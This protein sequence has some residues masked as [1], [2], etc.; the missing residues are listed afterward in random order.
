VRSGFKFEIKRNYNFAA[1][2]TIPTSRIPLQWIDGK[3]LKERA[4]LNNGVYKADNAPVCPFEESL[5]KVKPPKKSLNA[6]SQS[7]SPPL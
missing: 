4:L 7:V 2:S 6:A 5:H 1:T 3:F